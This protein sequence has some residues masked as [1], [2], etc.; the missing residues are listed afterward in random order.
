[1]NVLI[2]GYGVNVG[3]YATAAYFLKRGC[4]VRIT[5]L[6]EEKELGDSIRKLSEQGAEL[7]CGEHRVEDF[8]WA[9]LVIKTPSINPENPFLNFAKNVTNDYA[10]LFENENVAKTKLICITGTRGKTITSEALCHSL[11]KLGKK[12]RVCGGVDSPVFD[13]LSNWERSDI[14]EY[15]ICKMSLPQIRD[16]YK[17]TDGI[18]PAVELAVVTS[19][20]VN[21]K[22][23][24]FRNNTRYLLCS[25]ENKTNVKENLNISLRKISLIENNISAIAEDLPANLKT[26]YAILR[27][28]GFKSHDINKTLKSFKGVPHQMEIVSS[29]S[30]LLVINDSAATIPEAVGFTLRNIQST[31]VY[32]ICGGSNRNLNA[33]PLVDA[34]KHVSDIYLLDG[35]FTREKLMP[36]LDKNNIKYHGPFTTMEETVSEFRNNLQDTKKV[37]QVLLLSPGAP[38]SE[39][40]TDEFDRGNK[41]RACFK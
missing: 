15:L 33:Q 12:A 7:V 39:F 13:E 34:C 30:N 26:T 29:D 32:L 16:T 6:R 27:R 18:I 38:S 8:K 4:K 28:M 5:D 10:Y 2:Y 40:F 24:I 37:L 19:P 22:Y 21:E 3:G 36:L 1:M 9:D 41:F 20:V 31:C 23:E 17:Y 25:Q 35:S 11:N 14:P